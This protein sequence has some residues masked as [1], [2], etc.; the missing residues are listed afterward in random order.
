VWPTAISISQIK[1]IQTAL[2]RTT[3]FKPNEDFDAVYLGFRFHPDLCEL[4][5]SRFPFQMLKTMAD[6]IPKALQEVHERMV[7]A[8]VSRKT[9]SYL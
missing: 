9:V 4:L 5:I 8:V 3:A 1:S 2:F 7:R 6:S